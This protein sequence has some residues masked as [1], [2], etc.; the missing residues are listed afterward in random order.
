LAHINNDFYQPQKNVITKVTDIERVIGG[1]IKAIG[2]EDCSEAINYDSREEIKF[3]LGADRRTAISW[4]PFKENASVLEIGGNFGEITGELCDKAGQVIVTESSLFRANIIWERYKNRDNLE[5]YAGEIGDIKFPC[6]FDYII[7][8]N[9]VDKIGKQT[10]KN[11]NYISAISR[12]SEYLKADGKF[13]FADENLYSIYKCQNSEGSLNPWYHARNLH[14][15]QIETI[16]SKT[17]FHYVKFYYPL[18][19]YNLVGRI[20]SDANLPTAVEWNC[21]ANYNCVDQNYLASSMDL[22]QKL[23][24][25][26]M[27]PFFAPSFWVEA[28]R[29]DNLSKIEKVDVLFDESFELPILGFDWAQHGYNCVSDAIEHYKEKKILPYKENQNKLSILKI[30]QDSEVLTRVQKIELQL[31]QKLQ[32]VCDRHNLKLYGMYGTLLGAVRNAGMIPGDDDIDVALMREDFNK[33]LTLQ[34]EFTGEYFLQTPENDNCFYGGYLKLRNRN[35]TAVHP[36]NWWVDCCEGISIDIF[37]MD[38][39]FIDEVKERR[40]QKK[41]KLLQRLLYAKAY[42]YFPNFRDM[43]LLEWKTYKYIGKL[44]SRKQLTDKLMTVMSSGDSSNRAPFGIYA[45]YLGIGKPRLLNR[46]AFEKD[47]FIFY[48]EQRLR[49]PYGWNTVLN[50]LYGETYMSPRPWIEHKWRHGFYNTDVSYSVYKKRFNGLFRPMPAPEQK[51]VLFGDG[52]LFHEYFEKYTDEKY[53]PDHIVTLYEG[54]G[55]KS[56]QGIA[57]ESMDVISLMDKDNIYA[58]IC[59]IDI[60]DAEEKMQKA[61]FNDYFI[62]VKARERILYAN[63]TVI[64]RELADKL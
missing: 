40:K 23:T 39:G 12:L 32:S 29:E 26:K 3:Y 18:P 36:L 4:Y 24:D 59:S 28:G 33:L 58:I 14:R 2:K 37:P 49:V 54:N 63:P 57:I 64:L 34:N 41:I 38:N 53:K 50:N 51:I 31:L 17:G 52:Y 1:Y 42:G 20:Y 5:I 46:D 21:L 43:K 6:Q 48:E 30:D 47:I 22:V 25:N 55:L 8:M 13:L 19:F 61:G 9:L 45:H 7:I 10:V 16:M 11:E 60:R 56:V 62:F 44:F 35:T 27:F 15:S